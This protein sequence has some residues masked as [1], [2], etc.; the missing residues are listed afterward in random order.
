M[1]KWLGA[2]RFL[3]PYS[4]KP[5]PAILP[6][7]SG[8]SG[9]A[10]DV[11]FHLNLAVQLDQQNMNSNPDGPGEI[12]KFLSEKHRAAARDVQVLC[13]GEL[14]CVILNGRIIKIHRIRSALTEND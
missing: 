12:V 9:D 3:W 5:Q 13:V 7:H 6:M 4:L 14:R 11:S 8:A 1:S 10:F 2:E